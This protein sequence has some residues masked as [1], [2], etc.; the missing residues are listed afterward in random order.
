MRG[1]RT[2]RHRLTLLFLQW[3]GVFLAVSLLISY[4][5]LSRFRDRLTDDRLLLART[6]AQ[7]LD[8]TVAD[9][10]HGLQRL[11]SEL[12]LDDDP[13]SRLRAHR[14]QSLF[15][16]AIFV[17]DE[18]G[19]VLVADPPYAQ[20][21]PVSKLPPVAG[22][23]TLVRDPAQPPSLLAVYPF[24]RGG[25]RLLLVGETRP[26]GSSISVLL[27]ELAAGPDL[28]LVVVDATALVIAAP[29]Q[30]QLFRTVEPAAQLG[31]R[32]QA[33]R[34]L[35]AEVPSCT[36]C[37]AD[38]PAGESY[39]TAMAPLRAAPWGVVVQ[40]SESH[41][42]S[43]LGPSQL[44]LFGVT[45]LLVLMG[46]FLSH[47]FTRSV[48]V[49]IRDLSRRAQRLREGDLETPV[50]VEGDL[51]VLI[52]AE[53]LDEAR[54]RIASTLGDLQ[55]LNEGLET[56]VRKRTAEL[57][58]KLEDLRLLHAQ[59][60]TLVQRL[61]AAGEEERR[62]IARELHDETAQLLTV[63]QLSLER[64]C[65]GETG[66]VER[67]RDLL[68]RTQ[69]EIHRII[70]DLRPT[71]LDDLGLPAAV[72]SYAGQLAQHGIEVA[73]QVEEDIELPSDVEIT[74]FRIYQEIVTNILRHAHA[75]SVS[76][77]LYVAGGQLVLAV[78]DDGRGFAPAAPA[79]SAGLIG[80]QERAALVGGTVEIDSEPGAGTSVRLRI[81]LEGGTP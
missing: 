50:E 43:M 13:Q 49:P 57:Q 39:V 35:V 1:R 17:V 53:S 19:K 12:Q 3:L 70:H 14:F 11:S 6:V 40:Q 33:R 64:V 34:P 62:R 56:E 48:I 55:H 16:D 72:R 74:T 44:G 47:G 10:L 52:L 80:M 66:E 61:L 77:E 7:Y 36:V 46:L 26:V 78:E 28:H 24:R 68:R 51:E 81:P 29:D 15:R 63:V 18:D 75:E 79:D 73:L 67:A 27:Q 37:P 25:R 4:L 38:E 9:T 5:T 32:I 2:L 8:A 60:R 41:A 30:K 42:F 54:R 58:A 22:V 21:P 23:S 31:E 20:P 65:A 69:A 45:G 71:L 59:R 76:I